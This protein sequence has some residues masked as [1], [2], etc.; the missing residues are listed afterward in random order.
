MI[1]MTYCHIITS[2]SDDTSVHGRFVREQCSV[3]NAP[4]QT[5]HRH[6]HV[7]NTDGTLGHWDVY[8]QTLATT[9]DT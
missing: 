8:A 5:Y 6:L 2:V 3:T 1:Y 9:A 7:M 4:S